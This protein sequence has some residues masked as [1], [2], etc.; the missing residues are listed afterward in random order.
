MAN[1]RTIASLYARRRNLTLGLQDFQRRAEVYRSAIA[2][3]E[4]KLQALVP[5][6]PPFKPRKRSQNF[7]PREFMQ[8]YYDAVREL[9]PDAA[10][11]DSITAVLLRRKALDAS[12]IALRKSTR[13]RVVAARRRIKQHDVTCA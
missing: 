10:N 8:G 7:T 13:R 6:V 12:D 9:G 1:E 3:V 11:P 4:A 5:F 2:E